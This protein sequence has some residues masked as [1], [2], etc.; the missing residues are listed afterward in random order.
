MGL[1]SLT[2]SNFNSMRTRLG[3]SATYTPFGGSGSTIYI[4]YQTEQ[5]F[6]DLGNYIG[7][8]LNKEVN[9]ESKN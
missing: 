4:L 9:H 2:L 8:R 3:E 1:Q 5:L 7:A 6:D